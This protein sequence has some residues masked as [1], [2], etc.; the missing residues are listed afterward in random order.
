MGVPMFTLL[1]A[2]VLTEPL[3][4]K[5]RLALGIGLIVLGAWWAWAW[6]RLGSDT[7]S[8][9]W[10]ASVLLPYRRFFT[11]R[12]SV[13]QLDDD[14]WLEHRVAWER[15]NDLYFMMPVGLLITAAGAANLVAAVLD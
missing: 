13:R 8:L 1:I 7:T 4:T 12:S 6:W 11:L 9:R 2:V 10:Q 5:N 3:Y 14:R 15:R